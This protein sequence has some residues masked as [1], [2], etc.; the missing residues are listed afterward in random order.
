LSSHTLFFY[1][2]KVDRT[3]T[4]AVIDISSSKVLVHILVGSTLE[5]VGSMVE[6]MACK[7]VGS[8][9]D[10]DGKAVGMDHSTDFYR[11]SSLLMRMLL[12]TKPSMKAVILGFS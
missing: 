6:D 10:V 11:S 1:Q 4:S 7:L 2:S 5:A 9:L 3:V 12:P 8:T